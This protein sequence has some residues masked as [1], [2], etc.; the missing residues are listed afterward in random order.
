MRSK[1]YGG[2]AEG[3]KEEDF[4]QGKVVCQV[5]QGPFYLQKRRQHFGEKQ[6]E[7]HKG[8]HNLHGSVRERGWPVQ[9]V[10]EINRLGLAGL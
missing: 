4:Y 9:K 6:V 1:A 8:G 3:G 2:F 7:G 10:I 5:V